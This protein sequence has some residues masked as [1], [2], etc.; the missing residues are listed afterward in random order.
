MAIAILWKTFKN[1]YF[2]DHWIMDKTHSGY[3]SREPHQSCQPQLIPQD[4]HWPGPREEEQGALSLRPG[5][6]GF[7]LTVGLRIL[8]PNVGST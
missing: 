1:L 8:V 2:S 7:D 3:S 4:S 5:L 6:G